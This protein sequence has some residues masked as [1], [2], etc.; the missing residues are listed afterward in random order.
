MTDAFPTVVCLCFLFLL[1]CAVETVSGPR[2]C[3]LDGYDKTPQDP[4]GGTRG[5]SRNG[6]MCRMDR[7]P[8]P[9]AEPNLRLRPPPF[10]SLEAD[11][12]ETGQRVGNQE[13]EKK[14]KQQRIKE[15][16]SVRLARG[17]I[18]PR[19]VVWR[20]GFCSAR[21]V[22][23]RSRRHQKQ[24]RE[25]FSKPGNRRAGVHMYMDATRPIPL[26]S[27]CCLFSYLVPSQR[28]RRAHVSS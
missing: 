28:T 4:P 19:P 18:R 20:C 16:K 12:L 14:D 5:T 24:Q 2:R 21:H 7:G 25:C 10:P 9:M 6:Q 23:C 15:L 3:C 13:K 26:F 11:G 1:A 8:K 27:H 22:Y 17:L